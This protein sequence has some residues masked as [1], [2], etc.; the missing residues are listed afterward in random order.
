MITILPMADGERKAQILAQYPQISGRGDVIAM[1][2]QDEE[3]G[4]AVLSVE[5]DVVRIWDI[6]VNGQALSALD[7][8]GKLTADSLMRAAASYG[9]NFGAAHIQAYV[10]ALEAF[11]ETKGFQ[12]G[13]D[14]METPMTTIV[15]R[16]KPRD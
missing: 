3:F 6:T 15:H 13:E 8:M 14:C 9:E 16:T 5:G 7:M 10:P 1:A 2:E 11:L 12:K 4:T